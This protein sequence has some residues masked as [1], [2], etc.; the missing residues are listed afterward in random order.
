MVVAPAKIPEPVVSSAG[1]SRAVQGAYKELRFD[2]EAYFLGPPR[3]R[4][5]MAL[6]YV[7][8][9]IHIHTCIYVYAEMNKPIYIYICIYTC[10]Y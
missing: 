9:Y 2:F 1:C 8:I 10:V 3:Y 6:V 4:K 5:T 7:Y